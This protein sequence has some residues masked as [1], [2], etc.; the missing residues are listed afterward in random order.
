MVGRHDRGNLYNQNMRPVIDR[1]PR[2]ARN[3]KKRS[4]RQGIG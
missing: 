4:N 3:D 1:L 2:C